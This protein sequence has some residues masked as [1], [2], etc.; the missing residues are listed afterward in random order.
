MK[1]A[2]VGKGGAGKTT[3]SALFAAHMARTGIPVVAIDAD[4]NMHL[5]E[6]LGFLPM[7]AEK[8]IS[9]PIAA[10]TIQTHLRGTNPRIKDA[11]H[12]KKTTPPGS[13]S[14][15][16]RVGDAEDP[17]LSEFS[18]HKDNLRFMTVGTY[19]EEGIGTSCYHNNLSIFEN[20]LSHM[21]DSGGVVVADMVAGIDAFA[22]T[23]HA[24]FDLLVLIVEPTHRSVEVWKQYQALA[25]EAGISKSLVVIGNKV[26]SP[27]EETYLREHVPE[28]QL[29]GFLTR[30]S[31]LLKK[32][33][34]GG[35]F[36][37]SE[38]ESENIQLL[39][40]LK[41]HLEDSPVDPDVRL[42]MLHEL[43]TRYVAQASITERFGD[44]REQIDPSFSYHRM[45]S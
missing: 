16:I 15:L 2:F 31:Y 3:M 17:I 37:I 7:V 20:V 29:V 36:D 43:H 1:I 13:G 22:G 18:E 38:L 44:L 25:E 30:S 14:N 8:H 41:I 21:D 11:A 6:L 45:S 10:S 19:S 4:L 34:E 32:E 9:H 40:S 23:L 26:S 24:Q 12:F 39:E 42:K 5:G 27:E 35:A 33:R 28:S